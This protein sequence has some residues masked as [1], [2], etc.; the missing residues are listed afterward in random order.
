VSKAE[1]LYEKF[2][3]GRRMH[4]GHCSAQSHGF[5]FAFPSK[6]GRPDILAVKD[7]KILY[8]TAGMVFVSNGRKALLKSPEHMIMAR[9]GGLC[10]VDH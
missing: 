3:D 6:V 9:H 4:F 1:E 2:A 5:F 8:K 7:P 10:V